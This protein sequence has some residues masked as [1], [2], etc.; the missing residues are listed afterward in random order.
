MTPDT[1]E[2]A[3]ALTAVLDRIDRELARAQ[4]ETSPASTERVGGL[5]KLGGVLDKYLLAVWRWVCLSVGAD[6]D[7]TARHNDPPIALDRATAG[8][9]CF[10]LGTFTK[11]PVTEQAP[12]R[13]IFAEIRPGSALDR[14]LK[15][16]NQV[17]HDRETP[18]L[19]E[20]RST[21]T[22]LRAALQPQRDLLP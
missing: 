12:V 14:A 8:Q 16:R 22:A 7:S 6:P 17:V 1:H 20:V 3:T 18:A 13:W 10:L 2:M 11:Q 9:L 4:S 21:L 19:A 15:L 5:A